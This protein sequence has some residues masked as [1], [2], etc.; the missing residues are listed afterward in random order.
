MPVN[1]DIQR[2]LG[3]L[4]GRLDSQD[5]MLVE[6]KADMHAVT[7]H[8]NKTKGSWRLLMMLGGVASA[9]GAAMAEFI[10]W[11]KGGP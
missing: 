5:R 1:D 9:L 2:S 11:F 8:M 10:H 6:I 4:E 7:E 3:R